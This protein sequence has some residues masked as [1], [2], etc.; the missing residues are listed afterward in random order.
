MLTGH[1]AGVK[2]VGVSWGFRPKSEL[3]EY[4]ADIIIDSAKEIP[5]LL[6]A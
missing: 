2:T 6:D 4:N 3:K 5:G 1:N